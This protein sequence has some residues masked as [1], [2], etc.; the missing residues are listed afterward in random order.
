MA[1]NIPFARHYDPTNPR[2]AKNLTDHDWEPH[3][4][5]IEQYHAL[6][7]KRAR[8]VQML[9]ADRGFAVS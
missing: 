9:N 3:K 7:F 4:E 8:I 2:R 5:A 6:G 1:A